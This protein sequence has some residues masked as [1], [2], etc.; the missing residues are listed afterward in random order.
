M[1]KDINS[2]VDHMVPKRYHECLLN[3]AYAED[4]DTRNV[5]LEAT[6]RT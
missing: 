1:K 4:L 5:L 3:D 2:A 6:A